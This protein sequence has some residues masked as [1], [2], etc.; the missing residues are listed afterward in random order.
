MLSM[1][2]TCRPN[3]MLCVKAMRM[4]FSAPPCEA[5][6]ND[7]TR[8]CPGQALDDAYRKLTRPEGSTLEARNR[9]FHR[10]LVDGV[11][12]EYRNAEGMVRGAQAR[13]ID[14]RQSGR[15]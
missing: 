10:M 13:V 14:L 4:W 8:I 9:A 5:F 7:S 1:D 12:V 6:W 11:T 3:R 15:E 2:R